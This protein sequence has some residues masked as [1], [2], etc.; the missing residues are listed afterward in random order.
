M[1]FAG[2]DKVKGGLWHWRGYNVQGKKLLR[3]I[4]E[5]NF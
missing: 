2:T 1:D 3:T 4:I 5:S